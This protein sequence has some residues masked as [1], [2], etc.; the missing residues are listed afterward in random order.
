[1]NRKNGR[2]A[3]FCIALVR[4]HFLVLLRKPASECVNAIGKLALLFSAY[5]SRF[6]HERPFTLRI[7][8]ARGVHKL[9]NLFNAGARIGIQ[10]ALIEIFE[11]LR[12]GVKSTLDG[13]C[14]A[15]RMRQHQR[16]TGDG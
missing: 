9:L 13:L 7:C 8:N 3:A 12:L 1:M 16:A 14:F 5:Q 10:R 15:H 2:S 6:H 11:P 4:L